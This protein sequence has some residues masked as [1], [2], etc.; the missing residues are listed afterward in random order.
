MSG[1]QIKRVRLRLR[2][3]QSEFARTV[4][5]RRS[6]SVSDWERG[7]VRPPDAVLRAIEQLSHRT[8]RCNWKDFCERCGA[9]LTIADTEAERCTNCNWKGKG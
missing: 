8:D 2:Q 4:G 5:V 7:L 1:E 9:A 6:K 3:S